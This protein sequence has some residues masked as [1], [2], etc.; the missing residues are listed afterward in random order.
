MSNMLASEHP[1]AVTL[2][3]PAPK[4]RITA[5]L[6]TAHQ[7]TWN[8]RRP[9]TLIGASRQ[10]HIVLADETV[11]R[12]HGLIVNT[13]GEVLLKDLH[14]TNGTRCNGQPADLVVLQD[15]D[16]LRL[17]DTIFQVA[18]QVSNA[19][20]GATRAGGIHRDQLLLPE[21]LVLYRANASERWSVD[22]AVTIIG[23]RPGV[24][25]RLDHPEVSAVHAAVARIGESM[26]VFDLGSVWGTWVN[27]R[28]ETAAFLRAGDVLAV[29][30]FEMVVACV[31]AG[32]TSADVS[33][34]GPAR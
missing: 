10:A 7:K 1:R 2:P 18:V 24:A 16:V 13:G 25:I 9:V 6:G 12:A 22:R 33:P 19:D 31:A 11:S 26:A 34:A 14:S 3:P 21:P 29:G 15:G 17:G 20:P 30:P 23:R 8:L 32:C 28:R 4:V 27:H 5:G